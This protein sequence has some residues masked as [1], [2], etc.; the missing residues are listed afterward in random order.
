MTAFPSPHFRVVVTGCASGVGRGVATRLLG[1]HL[2]LILND[3]N[4]IGERMRSRVVGLG[5]AFL[6]GDIRTSDTRDGLARLCGA[7]VDAI[8]PCAARGPLYRNPEEIVETDFMAATRLVADLRGKIK[9]GGRVVFISSTAAYRN[10]WGERWDGLLDEALDGNRCE[11][12]WRDIGRMTSGEA[13]SLAKHCVLKATMRLARELAIH[14]ITVNCLASGPIKT[15]M[16]K[17]LWGTRPAM[18]ARLIAEAP[19]GDFSMPSDVVAHVL[20]LCGRSA[21]NTTGSVIHVDG[22]WHATNA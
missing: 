19:F 14:R 16:S 6:R 8:V 9:R 1:D 5:G 18:W 11:T 22:G 21:R 7:G 3:V 12:L 13:Y 10:E 2:P 4:H 15:S 20:F 17:P